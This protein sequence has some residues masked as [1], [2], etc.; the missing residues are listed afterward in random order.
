MFYSSVNA[1]K[2]KKHLIIFTYTMHKCVFRMVEEMSGK[3]KKRKG[4]FQER[5]KNKNTL[6]FFSLKR[7]SNLSYNRRNIIV[8]KIVLS[9]QI[10]WNFRMWMSYT[11]DI[12]FRPL[13]LHGARPMPPL[14]SIHYVFQNLWWLRMYILNVVKSSPINVTDCENLHWFDEIILPPNFL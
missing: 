5:V 10:L 12:C 9:F 14:P 8:H 13:K 1:E 7:M 2:S 6:L 4:Q 3:N 11:V